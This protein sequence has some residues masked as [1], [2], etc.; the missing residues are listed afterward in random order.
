MFDLISKFLLYSQNDEQYILFLM[1]PQYSP[2]LLNPTVTP[3]FSY[4]TVG[5]E[6]K[7]PHK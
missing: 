2:H 5:V 4:F 3:D 7:S 6:A 1:W